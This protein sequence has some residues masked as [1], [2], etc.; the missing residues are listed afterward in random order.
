[1]QTD[2]T[3]R[4][5]LLM[6]GAGTTVLAP[7]GLARAGWQDVFRDFMR[8]ATAPD[9]PAAAGLEVAE[10]A[11]GLKQALAQ[12]AGKAVSELGRTDGFWKR[13]A[14]RIRLPS[15]VQQSQ[16]I[17]SAA[18]FD[19]QVEQFR[20]TLNR[21]AETATAEVGDVVTTT[22]EQMSL[23]D[24]WGI[25]QGADDAATQYLRDTAGTAL[26]ERILPV[27]T[28]ATSQTGVTQAYKNMI[29]RSGPVADM[30]GAGNLD[31][32][33]HVT[34]GTLD[35]LYHVV[36]QEEARIRENP[37]ARTTELLEK[38]FSSQSSGG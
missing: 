38:V 10:V 11:E 4:R 32:D 27:V 16:A 36:A 22:I 30:L 23:Q 17:L 21:A 26:Y 29:A 12:G 2:R 9:S 1:M 6:L 20:L 33:D 28:N 7:A 24:A 35:G 3:R 13:D 31:L 15:V 14:V 5:I 19:T 18:G 37:A 34:R 25:L 8:G